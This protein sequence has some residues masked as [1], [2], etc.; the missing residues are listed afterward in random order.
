VASVS[1][2]L[3]NFPLFDTYAPVSGSFL[4]LAIEPN[5]NASFNSG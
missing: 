1:A 2:T 3:S 4:K 5:P